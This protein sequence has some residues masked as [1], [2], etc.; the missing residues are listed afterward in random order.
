M[1]IKNIV[2][3]LKKSIGRYLTTNDISIVTK[4][5]KKI[6]KCTDQL[7]YDVSETKFTTIINKTLLRP[8]RQRILDLNSCR[9]LILKRDKKHLSLIE[10]LEIHR[11]YF[12]DTYSEQL[13]NSI[14]Y[15]E[16][17]NNIE[18]KIIKKRNFLINLDDI[19]YDTLYSICTK[20][21]FENILNESFLEVIS[22]FDDLF[23]S[24]DNTK[25]ANQVMFSY[26]KKLKNAIQILDKTQK[27]LD[28]NKDN[29]VEWLDIIIKQENN[30]VFKS[31]LSFH[32]KTLINL[33]NH[34]HQTYLFLNED[35]IKKIIPQSKN[36]DV[37]INSN[38]NSNDYLDIHLT[39]KEAS[40]FLKCSIIT[41]WRL[42]KSGK[43]KWYRNG[44]NILYK[45][46]ELEDFIN[47]K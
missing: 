14:S 16:Y 17:S 39:Q 6:D 32:L 1:M 21:E 28:L 26:V 5:F 24:Q 2:N 12:I 34:F 29:V 3:D 42:R 15:E 43:L 10:E 4:E 23:K 30:T 33:E 9:N 19:D 8:L 35:E 18:T 25:H 37:E 27:K 40:E 22:Y 36:K 20:S 44:R 38:N 46:S 41:L 45:K 47:P 13:K 31:N 7:F 11:K